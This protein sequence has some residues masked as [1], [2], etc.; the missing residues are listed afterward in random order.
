MAEIVDQ[1]IDRRLLPSFNQRVMPRR[2]LMD[3]A[4]HTIN[5]G[6]GIQRSAWIANSTFIISLEL[7]LENRG[8]TRGA[9]TKY[10]SFI[11]AVKKANLSRRSYQSFATISI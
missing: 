8:G 4:L 1:A 5:G 11:L 9:T 10:D 2:P 6:D 3:L 7:E